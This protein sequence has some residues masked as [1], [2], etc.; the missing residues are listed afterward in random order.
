MVA[1]VVI[2]IVIN[3]HEE[4]VGF[5]AR[6]RWGGGVRRRCVRG[7]CRGSHSGDRQ[8][9]QRATSADCHLARGAAEGDSTA[10]EAARAAAATV[11]EEGGAFGERPEETA[12][13]KINPHA[14]S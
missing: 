8:R 12:G 2:A 5:G 1:H 11:G 3:K 14:Q 4:N 10:T 6:G 7:S 13:S 9:E